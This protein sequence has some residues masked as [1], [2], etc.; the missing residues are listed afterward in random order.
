MFETV[1]QQI[2]ALKQAYQQAETEAE[3]EQI[4]R[5]FNQLTNNINQLGKIS[6]MIWNAYMDSKEK[7][8]T[9]L[10]F[11]EVIHQ[12]DVPELIEK[13]KEYGIDTFTYSS[14]WSGAIEIAWLFQQNGCTLKGLIEINKTKNSWNGT[15]EKGPCFQFTIQK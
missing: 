2:E 3:K 4:K 11:S 13:L 15:V 12:Q 10:D 14:T 5:D 8:N 9:Y 6:V 7:E 1:Y